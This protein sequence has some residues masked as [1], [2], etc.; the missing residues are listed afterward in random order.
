MTSRGGFESNSDRF[1]QVVPESAEYRLFWVELAAKSC[2][3]SETYFYQT[4]RSLQ[5]MAAGRSALAEIT[6]GARTFAA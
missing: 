1:E 6:G 4:L 2:A 3:R 5:L